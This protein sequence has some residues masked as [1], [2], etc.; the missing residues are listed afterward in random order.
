VLFAAGIIAHSDGVG[1]LVSGHRDAMIVLTPIYDN[2]KGGLEIHSLEVPKAPKVLHAVNEKVHGEARTVI[3]T[4][5]AVPH[6]DFGQLELYATPSCE[7]HGGG[8]KGIAV[9]EHLRGGSRKELKV[10]ADTEPVGTAITALMTV[11]PGNDLAAELD[12]RDK[13][14]GS[15]STFSEC[16][17]VKASK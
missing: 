14:D 13:P 3:T 9:K 15:T 2:A 16:E 8:E 6:G 7:R 17:E 1:A 12:Q 4:E 5:L 10:D 11:T